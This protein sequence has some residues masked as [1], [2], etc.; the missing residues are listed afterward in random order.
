MK[1]EINDVG[2]CIVAKL[3]ASRLD[4]AIAATFRE[5]ILSKAMTS[6][7]TLVLDLSS[8]EFIDSSGLGALMGLRKRLGWSVRIVLAGLRSPVFRVFELAR[9]TSVFSFYTSVDAAVGHS[10]G[11]GAGWN[12]DAVRPAASGG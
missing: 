11:E 10:L 8:V 12:G 9:V 1:L 6:G 4:H 3:E 7:Q 2:G 5:E